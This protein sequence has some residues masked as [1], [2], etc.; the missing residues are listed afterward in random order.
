MG[1]LSKLNAK[2]IVYVSCNPTTLVRDSARLIEQGYRVTH[3]GVM[4]MFCHTGHV[5]SIVRFEKQP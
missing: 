2:R 4:D 3:A 1:Y 5:E